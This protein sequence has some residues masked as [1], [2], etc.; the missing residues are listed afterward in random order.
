M[1]VVAVLLITILVPALDAKAQQKSRSYW[2]VEGN[3]KQPDYTIIHFY[4][5]D[6]QLIDETRL[7]GKLLVLTKRKHVRYLNRRLREVEQMDSLAIRQ[8]MKSRKQ[9]G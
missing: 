9:K 1:Y 8:P 7:E 6:N 3:T 4:G 2:V 5:A